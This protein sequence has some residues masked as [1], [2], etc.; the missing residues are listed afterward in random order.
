MLCLAAHVPLLVEHFAN[1]AERPHYQHFP[2]VLLI[3]C[4][5][6]WKRLVR[7]PEDRPG[8]RAKVLRIFAVRPVAVPSREFRFSVLTLA[9]IRQ[10]RFCAWGNHFGASGAISAAQSMGDLA[11]L[12]IADSDPWAIRY[13]AL[14]VFTGAYDADQW[15]PVRNR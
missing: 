10:F 9:D 7:R 6:L 3:G 1:L 12:C 13:S 5:L 14:A 15:G 4:W 2:I 11:D 8:S